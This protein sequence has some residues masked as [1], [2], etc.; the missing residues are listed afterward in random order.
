MEPV[1]PYVEACSLLERAGVRYL[2]VG[3]FAVNL[4]AADAGLV[5]ATAD[6]DVLIA[7]D[8]DVLATAIAVLRAAGFDIEAGGE[9]LPDED[10][11]VLS[12]IVR[13]SAR[14]RCTKHSAPVDLMLAMRGSALD[15][16]W[17]RQR[18]FDVEGGSLRVAPLEAVLRSKRLAN[19]PKDRA[20]LEAHADALR[21]LLGD[22]EE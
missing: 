4:H 7:A 1:D 14:V 5:I 9:P 6:C 16:L 2:V 11:V 18:R 15:E 3:A 22:E 21:A 17:D 20:F 13:S 19:R 10:P 8:A 12:G